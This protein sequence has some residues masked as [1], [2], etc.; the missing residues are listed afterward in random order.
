MASSL[1]NTAA[2]SSDTELNLEYAA[3]I[4]LRVFQIYDV[5]N[6][7]TLQRRELRQLLRQCGAT[8][9]SRQCDEII[10]Q[11]DTDGDGNECLNAFSQY[12]FKGEKVQLKCIC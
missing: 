9:S 3:S 1:N 5:D 4:I 6:G 7:G 8:L 2:S 12:L 11:L 10:D